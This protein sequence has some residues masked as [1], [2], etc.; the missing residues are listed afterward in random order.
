MKSLVVLNW[1]KYF[2]GTHKRLSQYMMVYGD[3]IY[4]KLLKS[5][6][7]AMD[8][9]LSYVFL[10]KFKEADDMVCLIYKKD[11][12]ELLKYMLNWYSKKEDYIKCSELQKI[13]QYTEKINNV[14]K[15]KNKSISMTRY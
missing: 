7:N 15:K 13:I 8:L 12:I 14:N 1:R 2:D 9:N 3:L 11:Y 5:I 10:F 4:P 6:K